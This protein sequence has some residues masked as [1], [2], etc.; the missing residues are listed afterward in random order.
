MKSIILLSGGIDSALTTYLAREDGEIE[1][2][3]I[4]YGQSYQELVAARRLAEWYNKQLYDMKVPI[5]K[6]SHKHTTN[7]IPAR[8]QIL[9]SMALSWAVF[10]GADHL[11]I[12]ANKDDYQDYPDCR[13]E[14]FE[15]FEA[16]SQAYLPG[17][18]V[19]APLLSYTKKDVIHYAI[20]KGIPLEL[21]HTCYTPRGSLACGHCNAC[22]LRL[23]SFKEIGMEDPAS[24]V[25]D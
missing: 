5:I 21:T 18:K 11:A 9:L 25:Q 7:Y 8:N 19:Y 22:K 17:V 12:G 1:L 24:Y 6:S 16:V 2:L 10:V 4:D 3:F 20:H 13:P 23:Q 14:W 15:K